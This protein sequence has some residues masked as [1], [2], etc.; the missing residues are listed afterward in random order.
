MDI[1]LVNQLFQHGMSQ[2]LNSKVVKA[3]HIERK[4]NYYPVILF[5]MRF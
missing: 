2:N 4:P 3:R 5:H 1:M